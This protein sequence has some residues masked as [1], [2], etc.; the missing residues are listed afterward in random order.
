LTYVDV[1]LSGETNVDDDKADIET[2][3]SISN[4][5][6]I[7]ELDKALYNWTDTVYVT[8]TAPDH[9]NNSASEETI[10]TST[11]P[12][13]VTSRA[14]KMCTTAQGSTFAVAAETGPDTGV[15]TM[16][17]A[18]TGYS[19]GT[20]NNNP[21]ATANTSTCSATSSTGH[22]LILLDRLTVYPFHTNTLTQ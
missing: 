16:E 1:G 10:G 18:L 4:F 2:S 9:N 22:D 15:F 5:G 19:L 7:V 3:F 20:A 11:L 12:I 21:Q 13:Q 17:V 14:G 8:I 6:A